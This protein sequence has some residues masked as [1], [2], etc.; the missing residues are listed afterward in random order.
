MVD[1]SAEPFLCTVDKDDKIGDFQH[2]GEEFVYILSG[3]I[4]YTIGRDSIT[5]KAGDS[6]YFNSAI[7]H[8]IKA[9]SITPA[10]LILVMI[11]PSPRIR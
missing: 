3:K 1:K 6:L 4:I 5:L 10:K 9:L 2:A 11:T 8:S 7:V